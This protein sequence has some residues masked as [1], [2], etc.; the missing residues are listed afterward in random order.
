MS[1]HALV[2]ATLLAQLP[3]APPTHAPDHET[4]RL[5]RA[6]AEIAKLELEAQK[7]QKEH[8]APAP[9]VWR[10]AQ[11]SGRPWLGV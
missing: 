1:I 11:A 10:N 2:L 4:P 9:I 7:A 5:A 6:R 8:R 3:P